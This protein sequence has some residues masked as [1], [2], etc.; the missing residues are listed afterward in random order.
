MTRVLL[1]MCVLVATTLGGAATA[2]TGPAANGRIA[3]TSARGC[4]VGSD[5][6]PSGRTGPASRG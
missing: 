1:V 6:S 5:L 4:P 2:A 3:F